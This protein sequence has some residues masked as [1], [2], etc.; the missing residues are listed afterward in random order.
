MD[1]GR[2]VEERV[3]LEAENNLDFRLG[4]GTLR[5]TQAAYEGDI[6]LI[7]RKDNAEYEL[8]IVHKT[9]PLYSVIIKYAIYNIGNRG[10]RYGYIANSQLMKIQQ[11]LL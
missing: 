4:T 7:T 10:K 2:T 9:D 8:R 6:A 3:T 1:I 11:S 5:N